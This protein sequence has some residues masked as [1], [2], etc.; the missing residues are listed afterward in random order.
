MT[1]QTLSQE[2]TLAVVVQRLDDL[3]SD[4]KTL[5]EEWHGSR[6]DVVPRGEWVQRNTTVDTRFESQ[7]REIAEIKQTIAAARA[8]WWAWLSPVVAVVALAWAVFGP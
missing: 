8:P 7:G 3:R 6:G 4:V 2:A 1:G 5:R